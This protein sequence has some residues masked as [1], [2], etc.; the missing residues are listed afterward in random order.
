MTP[1]RATFG[2]YT[3][4]YI[5]CRPGVQRLRNVHGMVISTP[6]G[7]RFFR[8]F[9]GSLVI[10]YIIEVLNDVAHMYWRDGFSASS[11]YTRM[12]L[13]NAIECGL[14]SGVYGSCILFALSYAELARDDPDPSPLKR[15][16]SDDVPAVGGA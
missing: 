9:H 4:E 12:S 11:H 7:S 14:V 5:G 6:R 3:V 16:W 1:K 13:N 2:A 15:P 8:I 10:D